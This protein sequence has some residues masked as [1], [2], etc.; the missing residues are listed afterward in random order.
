MGYDQREQTSSSGAAAAIVA[1][2]LIIAVLGFVVVGGAALFWVRAARMESEVAVV[3]RQRAAEEVI[4][5]KSTDLRSALR[6][7]RAQATPDPRLNFEVAIDREG[8]ATVGGDDIGLDE[9]R[10]KLVELQEETS[11]VFSVH[12]NAD[13][14]CPIR[15]V[16]SVLDV[17]EGVGDID[18]RVKSVVQLTATVSSY[19]PAAEWDHFDDGT[20][21]AYD[22]IQLKVVS[23]EPHVGTT[24]SITVPPPEL[25]EDSPIRTAGTRLTFT[26]QA[27]DLNR[28]GLA[29]GAIDNPIIER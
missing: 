25:P 18:Y 9:L 26:L 21:S 23:P 1:A 3:A 11:N 4:R 27:S 13:S 22:T 7:A 8:N 28:S 5:A 14:E 19:E 6:E 17:C 24:L 2:V 15:H 10:E 12:I 16:V 20:F 29:W